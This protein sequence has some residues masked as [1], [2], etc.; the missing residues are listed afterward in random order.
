MNRSTGQIRVQWDTTE[1]DANQP[2]PD[3]HLKALRASQNDS[4]DLEQFGEIDP[5]TILSLFR[6]VENEAHCRRGKNSDT[7]WKALFKTV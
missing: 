6:L 4:F 1:F 7:H 2:L 3:T 5:D